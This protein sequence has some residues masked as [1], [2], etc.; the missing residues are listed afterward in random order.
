M[1]RFVSMDAPVD[2]VDIKKKWLS[3]PVIDNLLFKNGE[4]MRKVSVPSS[5]ADYGFLHRAEKTYL[6]KCGNMI[7]LYGMRVDG[8]LILP[9]RELDRARRMLRFIWLFLMPIVSIALSI[10]LPPLSA[11]ALAFPIVHLFGL[12]GAPPTHGKIL[13]M[14]SSGESHKEIRFRDPAVTPLADPSVRSEQARGESK[15]ENADEVISTPGE[16]AEAPDDKEGAD[17]GSHDSGA[18]RT[19]GSHPIITALAW[20]LCVLGVFALGGAILSAI[21]M[22]PLSSDTLFNSFSTV[23]F[24]GNGLLLNARSRGTIRFGIGAQLGLNVLAFLGFSLLAEMVLPIERSG[25]TPPPNSSDQPASRGTSDPSEPHRP[26]QSGAQN[27]PGSAAPEQPEPPQRPDRPRVELLDAGRKPRQALRYEFTPSREERFVITGDVKMRMQKDG[28]RKSL[29]FPQMTMAGHAR[30]TQEENSGHGLIVRLD[31]VEIA[32]DKKFPA[33]LRKRMIRRVRKLEGVG[34]KKLITERGRTI[35]AR[36]SFPE[37]ANR[38]IRRQVKQTTNM[39]GVLLP[40]EPVGEG[41]K[42]RIEIPND[43]LKTTTMRTVTLTKIKGRRIV[44][45]TT[46]R[47]GDVPKQSVGKNGREATLIRFSKEG[48]GSLALNMNHLISEG[49]RHVSFEQAIRIDGKLMVQTGTSDMKI[50]PVE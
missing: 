42:W 48:Q 21:Q 16:T 18:V 2:F 8:E 27:T 45:D 7:L 33:A 25:Y 26:H 14:V 4:V 5:C 39:L 9:K 23:F 17:V 29:K 31:R 19:S 38:S 44:I 43:E 15:A 36:Y 37:D 11:P 32:K 1:S 28:S 47:N 30:V 10:V 46:M 12:N 40:E 24:L 49:Q 3:W 20:L 50:Q 34:W 41:A 6:Y 13:K 22:G 35:E